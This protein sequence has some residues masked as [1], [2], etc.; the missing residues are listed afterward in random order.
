MRPIKRRDFIKWLSLTPFVGG[1]SC[2]FDKGLNKAIF[3]GATK[4]D[5]G[6]DV[7]YL[8]QNEK[9]HFP[10][11]LPFEVHSIEISKDLMAFFPQKPHHQMAITDQNFKNLKVLNCPDHYSFYGHGVIFKESGKESFIYASTFNNIDGGILAI[12]TKTLDQKI[13]PSYGGSPHD[14]AIRGNQLIVLNSG[15]TGGVRNITTFECKKR[16]LKLLNKIAWPYDNINLMHFDL[17]FKKGHSNS[18]YIG[19]EGVDKQNSHDLSIVSLDTRNQNFVPLSESLIARKMNSHCLSLVS[20]NDHRFLMA[21][22]PKGDCIVLFDNNKKKAAETIEIKKPL[23]VVF[24]NDNQSF[25]VTN[26]YGQVF[27]YDLRV[28]KLFQTRGTGVSFTSH[29]TTIN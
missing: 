10:L 27:R 7:V 4:T 8:D 20:S 2:V 3:L 14:M 12:N 21:T 5:Y 26:H 22:S 15:E 9:I 18:F 13:F 1:L 19:L 11:K 29:L 25:Y 17:A 23:G 6:S 16:S 24:N 28:K